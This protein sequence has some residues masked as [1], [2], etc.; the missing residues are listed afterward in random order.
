M[1]VIFLQRRARVRMVLALGIFLAVTGIRAGT[2][3][4]RDSVQAG[5]GLLPIK[6]V[7]TNRQVAALTFDISRGSAALRQ[8]L[9]VLKRHDV[10]ATFFVNGNWALEN[11]GLVRE[12][13]AAGHELA[14]GGHW[15][16]K[17]VALPQER[18]VE[19]IR[20]S[21]RALTEVA[22]SEPAPLFRP[23]GGYSNSRLVETALDEGYHTVIWS[24][25]SRDT[26]TRDAA[27]T[28]RRVV[29]EVR[30]GD[31]IRFS[32]DD[33]GHPVAAALDLAI[34]QLKAK[35]FHLVTVGMLLRAE[36]E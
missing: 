1:V 32:A 25:D 24:L 23:P 10:R 29:N 7:D 2:V 12:L 4:L 16:E 17:L 26:A 31:I 18:V 21:H 15:E 11:P 22:G 33:G 5:A 36:V 3:I 8:L 34:T 9:D 28:A 14:S 27:R 6:R 13:V 19:S 20:T 30:P 35:G